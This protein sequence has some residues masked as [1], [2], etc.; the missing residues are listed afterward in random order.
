[1]YLQM[2]VMIF[3]TR[4]AFLGVILVCRLYLI[5]CFQLFIQEQEI[6]AESEKQ[7]QRTL[8][9]KGQEMALA[10]E[11]RDLQKMAALSQ[12]DSEKDQLQQVIS[13]LQQVNTF[14]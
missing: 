2:Q 1:M 7:L 5:E 9:E 11:E 6:M 13:Q 14:M 12:Q 4:T 10:I 3:Q 8:E